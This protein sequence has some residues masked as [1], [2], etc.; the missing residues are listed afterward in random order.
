MLFYHFF[1]FLS[2]IWFLICSSTVFNGLFFFCTSS[3][4]FS[5]A[6]K[7]C[8]SLYLSYF[9][10]LFSSSIVPFYGLP[11]LFHHTLFWYHL[12]FLSF[13]TFFPLSF[14]SFVVPPLLFCYMFNLF[15]SPL[16]VTLFCYP[17][18][19]SFVPFSVQLHVYHL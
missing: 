17:L 8:K 14:V 7:R 3:N 12:L 5:T 10:P 2:L 16:F 19:P 18:S 13:A 4:P 6:A 9:V 1:P 15:R 11:L